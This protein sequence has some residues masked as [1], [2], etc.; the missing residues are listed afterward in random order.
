MKEE[1]E[2]HVINYCIISSDINCTHTH[3]HQSLGDVAAIPSCC[4]S[5]HYSSLSTAALR[6]SVPLLISD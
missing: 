6:L 1:G 5:A 2:M 3:S 4:S